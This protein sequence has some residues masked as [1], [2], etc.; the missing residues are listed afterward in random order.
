MNT[1]LLLRA[2]T[3]LRHEGLR[4]FWFGSWAVLGYRRLLVLRRPLSTPIPACIP[5][6]PVAIAW[7]GLNDVIAYQALRSEI[8]VEAVTQRLVAGDRCLVAWHEDV[9][10][11]VMWG[12][13]IRA[14]SPY[15]GR[16]LELAPGE[17]FQFDGFTSPAARGQ[18][19]APSLS[20]AWLRHLREEGHSAAIRLTLPENNAALRAHA[21]AGYRVIGIVRSLKLGPWRFHA[22]FQAL[23]SSDPGVFERL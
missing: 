20:M 16:D 11:G 6:L 7:L 10:V 2:W 3:T 23:S 8:C 4:A 5:S 18:G 19:I 12:S 21:K 1:P 15:L 22:P 9:I 17:A 14:Q 13:T